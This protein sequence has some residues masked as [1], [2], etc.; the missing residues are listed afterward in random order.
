MRRIPVAGRWCA[1]VALL[2]ALAWTLVVPPFQVADETGHLVYVQYL[3]EK[4]EVPD[5]PNA[6]VFSPEH[7]AVLDA[8]RF[9]S[10]VGRPRDRAVY[11][12]LLDA[13]VDRA[14]DGG[15]NPLGEG[16][17]VE[18][19]SQPPLYYAG[20]AVI[21][22]ASPWRGLLERMWLMRAFSCLLAAATTLF[23]FMFLRE[24]LREPWTWTVGALAVALQPVFSSTSSGLTPDGLLFAASAATLFGL[25][26]AFKR[27]LTPGLGAGIGVALA[28]GT[29]AKLNFV[30]L[31][32]GALLGL[33]LLVA[34]APADIRRRAVVGAG[35][36]VGLLAFGVLAYAVLN[37]AVWDR[38]ALAGGVE[39]AANVAAGGTAGRAPGEGGAESRQAQLSYIWQLYLPR[40]PV[41]NA[42]FEYFPP[43]HTW[44]R[45]FV[46]IFGWLDT[47]FPSWVYKL[48][49][50]L[51]IPLVGLFGWSLARGRMALRRRLSEVV[52]YSAITLGLLV[53]IGILGLRYVNDT[54]F[55]FEQFRYL[56][57]L[58]PFYAAAIALAVRAPGERLARPLAAA[59]LTLLIAHNA[60]A[61]FLVISRFYG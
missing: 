43:W 42:Q 33:G 58:A 21:Y 2:N 31:L 37:T 22:K 35:A 59:V 12:D 27:G 53:S 15:A 9:N 57:P 26:R 6:A 55:A 48:A 51:S 10:V 54:G 40:L 25:A 4:G 36:A 5:N 50:G 30:A 47:P 14:E 7:G 1:L 13:D 3:A 24:L 39:S 52:C 45:G 8:L 16:G 56:L 49:L 19:S 41:M 60:F 34:R 20:Q 38:P 11:S 29:L 28:V 23:T 32:P 46:G 17:H 44:F 61:Q 18:S